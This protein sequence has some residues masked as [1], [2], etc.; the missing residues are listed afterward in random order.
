MS[1]VPTQ[2]GVVPRRVLAVGDIA[3]TIEMSL[4]AE[5]VEVAASG[6]GHDAARKLRADR[7]FDLVV[8]NA[9]LTDMS[10]YDFVAS[11]LKHMP[12]MRAMVIGPGL[13]GEQA[14]AL[15][16]TGLVTM[17]PTVE[18]ALALILPATRAAPAPAAF[19]QSFS[20]VFDRIVDEARQVPPRSASPTAPTVVEQQPRVNAALEAE[21][22]ILR[23]DAA[24]AQQERA[25]LEQRAIAAEQTARAR[26]DELQ[27]ALAHAERLG[28]ERDGWKRDS[29][30]R[31]QHV[32]GMS[33][34]LSNLVEIRARLERELARTQDQL[35]EA[36]LA[37]DNAVE[38]T[39]IEMSSDDSTRDAQTSSGTA[40]EAHES[41][42]SELRDRVGELQGALDAAHQR[43]AGLEESLRDERQARARVDAERKTLV[44]ERLALDER[45]RELSERADHALKVPELEKAVADLRASLQQKERA[46]AEH[47]TSR[48]ALDDEKSARLAAEEQV[49]VVEQRATELEQALAA[50]TGER[51][52][53]AAELESAFKDVAALERE[54]EAAAQDSSQMQALEAAV[55]DAER[56]AASVEKA[57]LDERAQV[58][59]MRR[60]LDERTKERDAALDEASRSTAALAEAQAQVQAAGDA[61][62]ASA[63]LGLE[64]EN[65]RAL[66]QDALSTIERLQ[67]R[68]LDDE[69][70][71]TARAEAATRETARADT[72]EARVVELEASL[73]SMRGDLER[74]LAAPPPPP[75]TAAAAPRAPGGDLRSSSADLSS[76]VDFLS[77]QVLTL[78]E[79]KLVL[80]KL[81][82]DLRDMLRTANE[83]LLKALSAPPARPAPSTKPAANDP[84]AHVETR[85][86]HEMPKVALAERARFLGGREQGAVGVDGNG[87]VAPEGFDALPSE[88]AEATR[89]GV[90]MPD[91]P[92]DSLDVDLFS[93]EERGES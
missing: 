37:R 63:V 47:A 5:G 20:E 60:A 55:R 66:H 43:A 39:R 48:R 19:E 13:T 58:K 21:L 28:E 84:L 14:R 71:E 2:G 8:V 64:L 89:V 87:D 77:S 56:R 57:L 79:E 93:L 10:A 3:L 44:D 11:M 74:A 33:A 42:V 31:R 83:E 22:S 88:Q 67:Q 26:A 27:A 15:S 68:L 17:T 7:G 65:A 41:A 62:G 76:T 40:T 49:R 92:D 70:T 35:A 25:A 45:L 90:T 16:S 81:C 18:S 38:R 12:G 4:G 75:P 72:A 85:V 29:E 34:Q 80:E 6:G 54:R 32:D 78:Q 86:A 51:D 53:T 82:D 52:R 50:V 24:R 61:Q 69:E 46:L 1:A 23:R 9:V 36:E 91:L 73:A 30:A 59:E